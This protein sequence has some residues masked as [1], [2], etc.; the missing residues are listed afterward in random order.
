MIAEIEVAADL[1]MAAGITCL[2]YP[3]QTPSASRYVE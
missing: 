1:E 2:P 3:S